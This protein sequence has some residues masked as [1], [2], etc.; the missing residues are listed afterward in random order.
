MEQKKT[1]KCPFCGHGKMITKIMDYEIIDASG[2]KVIIPDIEVD[3]CD[4]C[5]EKFFGYDA[6][7]KLEEVKKK[8][9][10]V[11]LN[12]R[13]ELFKQISNLAEKH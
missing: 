1:Y 6:A 5:S 11:V 12:L 9:N 4:T 7:L 13:P 8:G 3:I 10:R 2:E